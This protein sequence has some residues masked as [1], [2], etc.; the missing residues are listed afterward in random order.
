MSFRRTDILYYTYCMSPIALHHY[1]RV[2]GNW[3]SR[4]CWNMHY[5]RV[6]DPGL[7]NI[8]Y[9]S[10][11]HMK[12]K[13]RKISFFVHVLFSSCP[14]VLNVTDER[15]VAR[16]EFNMS[17]SRT[18]ILYYTYCMSPIALHHYQRVA[19]NWRSRHCWNM[20]Y[21]LTCAKAYNTN[22]SQ[23]ALSVPIKS[24]LFIVSQMRLYNNYT[25]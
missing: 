16:F 14:I 10:E 8:G 12:P 4:H 20:H 5:E 11:T 1:Q 17:F 25:Q 18:D 21:G 2:A 24:F 6:R 15:D 9:Q 7:C 3:R 22:C 19:G 13:S 23:I